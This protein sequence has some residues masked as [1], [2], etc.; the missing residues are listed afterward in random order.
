MGDRFGLN[1]CK[2][3][4]WLLGSSIVVRLLPVSL[5]VIDSGIAALLSYVWLYGVNYESQIPNAKL[6]LI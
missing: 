1:I 6:P 3:L 2:R 5:I 4:E